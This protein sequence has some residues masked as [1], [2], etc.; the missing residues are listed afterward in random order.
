MEGKLEDALEG[1][2]QRIYKGGQ[3]LEANLNVDLAIAKTFEERTSK[4]T[5]LQKENDL[6]KLQRL[7]FRY[8]WQ[9]EKKLNLKG[10]VDNLAN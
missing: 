9:L 2:Y 4:F 10:N 1:Y 7:I 5:N 3:N 6:L 8:L